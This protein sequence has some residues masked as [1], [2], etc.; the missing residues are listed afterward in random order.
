YLCSLA[1]RCQQ[2]LPGSFENPT[3]CRVTLSPDGKRL[4]VAARDSLIP[5]GNRAPQVQVWDLARGKV[6]FTLEDT[7]GPVTFSPDGRTLA[8]AWEGEP[9]WGNDP[10][11]ELT[12]V[13]DGRIKLCDAASGKE[14][15]SFKGTTGSIAFSPDGKHL[16]ST[17]ADGTVK[18]WDAESGKE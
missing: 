17:P 4:A 18:L 15:V 1:N 12:L 16:A 7:Q 5:K 10:D 6:A 2:I 3:A 11:G 9:Q 13:V 8:T 14:L